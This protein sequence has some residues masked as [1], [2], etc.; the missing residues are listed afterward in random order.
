MEGNTDDGRL[1]W[2]RDGKMYKGLY[3]ILDFELSCIV[4]QAKIALNK[5]SYTKGGSARRRECKT[6]MW[7]GRGSGERNCDFGVKC[8]NSN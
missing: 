7:E 5:S 6:Y 8:C 1:M 4:Y 2:R 3:Q